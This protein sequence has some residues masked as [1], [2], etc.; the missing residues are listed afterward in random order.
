MRCLVDALL[1]PAPAR[2]LAAEGHAA[3]HVADKGLEA[4]SDAAIWEYA[5]QEAA[6][7]ITKDGERG[8]AARLRARLTTPAGKS[9]RRTYALPAQ[10]A[11]L[12]T[13]NYL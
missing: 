1:P 3:E 6:V 11:R 7:I 10:C 8:T 12:F 13:V 9:R 2:R 5:L 4:A